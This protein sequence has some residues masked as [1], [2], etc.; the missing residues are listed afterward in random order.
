M[1]SLSPGPHVEI[2]KERYSGGIG[3]GCT[4]AHYRQPWPP[5]AGSGAV[6]R[7]PIDVQIIGAFLEHRTTIAFAGKVER[8]FGGFTSP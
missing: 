2:R 4:E 6:H 7:L 8:E 3:D 5:T 1:R